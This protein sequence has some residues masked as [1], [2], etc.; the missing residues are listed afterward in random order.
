MRNT[1]LFTMIICIPISIRVNTS[2]HHTTTHM[3]H[4][5]S[6]SSRMSKL[7]HELVKYMHVRSY[8]P[9]VNMAGDLG[10]FFMLSSLFLLVKIS[11][12]LRT[13][14]STFYYWAVKCG[15]AKNGSIMHV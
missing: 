3:Y 4:L 6:T 15:T 9:Q 5:D 13:K 1:F 8:V 11:K 12:H 10:G 14:K 2:I 7:T